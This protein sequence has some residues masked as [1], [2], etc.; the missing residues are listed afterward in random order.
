MLCLLSYK[1]QSFEGVID[2]LTFGVQNTQSKYAYSYFDFYTHLS[3]NLPLMV[4]QPP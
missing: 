1:Q 2:H 3:H 4:A